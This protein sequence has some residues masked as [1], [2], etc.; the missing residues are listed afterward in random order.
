MRLKVAINRAINLLG[1]WNQLA[2]S[3]VCGDVGAAVGENMPDNSR[4]SVDTQ[5]SR[6]IGDST[7]GEDLQITGNVSSKGEIH[8]DG[9]VHGDVSCV[10]LVL[11]ESATLEGNVTAED[12]VIR[13]R[14]IGSIRAL[15]VT[16]QSMSHVEG[17][18]YHQ[19]LALEQGAFFEG[20]SRRSDDPMGLNHAASANGAAAKSS[21]SAEVAEPVEP[22]SH[23]K[24]KPTHKFT[25]SLPES[26]S[27]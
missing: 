4:H 21:E 22:P 23:R 3:I 17:D 11:G 19:S 13:G 15:R 27:V 8:L 26:H 18:I 1:P 24:D 25:R 12:V 5:A 6:K 14:L 20:R 10:A 7:I 2:A 9:E 16:L